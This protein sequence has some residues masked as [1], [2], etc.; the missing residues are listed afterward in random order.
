MHQIKRLV[1]QLDLDPMVARIVVI[2]N[3]QSDHADW[4]AFKIS[5]KILCVS[6]LRNTGYAGGNQL[7][8]DILKSLQSENHLCVL[9]ADVEFPDDI[10]HVG[11]LLLLEDESI[12]LVSFRTEDG[13][14]NFLYDALKLRGLIHE[15]P[16]AHEQRVVLSD[17]APGSFFLLRNN[18]LADIDYL[19]YDPFFLYWEEVD[20][21]FRLR[22][23]GWG[24]VCCNDCTI[25]RSANPLKANVGSI[26]YIVRN[27]FLFV[28]RNRIKRPRWARFFFRY[29]LASSRLALSAQTAKPLFNFFSGLLDGIRGKYGKR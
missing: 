11:L 23:L 20:L 1:W 21:S 4:E 26:Y 8:F 5:H 25:V 15:R 6:A 24:I 27:A 16:E 13:K 22:R 2:N 28:K 9:N 7:G 10:L 18:A 19:F 3:S 14:S 17:Y 29:F 12:G